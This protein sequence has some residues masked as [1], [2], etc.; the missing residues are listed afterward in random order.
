MEYNKKQL[1]EFVIKREI[2]KELN[3]NDKWIQDTEMKKGK[4]KKKL[5]IK[6][7]DTLTLT[8][9]NDELKK[10]EHKYKNTDKKMSDSDLSLEKELNL[11]KSLMKIK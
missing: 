11:A 6:D 8:R 5:G 4:L 3:E 10:L 1:V 9:I 7:D 2:Y